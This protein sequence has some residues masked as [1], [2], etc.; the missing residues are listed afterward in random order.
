MDKASD[1]ESEHCGFDSRRC[2]I[3]VV[4]ITQTDCLDIV[5]GTE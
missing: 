2:H 5:A 4:A 3:Y 1:F